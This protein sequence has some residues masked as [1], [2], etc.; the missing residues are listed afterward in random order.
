MDKEKC[1]YSL[2]IF[3]I[4]LTYRTLNKTNLTLYF[5][6]DFLDTLYIFNHTKRKIGNIREVIE[7]Q[8]K[9]MLLPMTT[10]FMA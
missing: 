8:K 2:L 6:S 1:M 3:D 4:I 9:G 7:T 10:E 5:G